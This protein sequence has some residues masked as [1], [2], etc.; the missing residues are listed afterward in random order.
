M[1]NL[2]R[3]ENVKQI[4]KAVQPDFEALAQ[5]HGAVSYKKEA[6]YALRAL[7][8]N[9]YL[10]SVALGN[11]DSLKQAI[12]DVAAVGLTLNPVHGFAYLIPRKSKVCLDI[13]YRGHIQLAAE[14]G[15]IKYC[16][17][18]IVRE[19]D[20]YVYKGMSTRPKHEFEAFADR[21]KIKGVYCITK[22]QDGEILVDQMSIAEVYAIRD[23]SES[24]KAYAKDK[25]KTSPWNTDEEEMVKKTL[26]RRARKSWPLTDKRERIEKAVAISDELDPIELTP[27]LPAPQESAKDKDLAEIR[28]GLKTLKR[29]EADF[30]A[31]M[32]RIARRDLKKLEDMTP[33]ETSNA[34][35]FLKG[36]VAQQEKKKGAA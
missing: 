22:M 19:K 34:L 10:M 21:G 20:K 18:E 28:D 33:Q 3:V 15:C 16:K 24:W 1:S 8:E 13:G 25:T 32:V 35:I 9:S 30:L 36:V 23:R 12:I 2:E 17:A 6:S 11:L 27:V 31:Y 7:N 29:T 5:I 26:I 14:S 4:V